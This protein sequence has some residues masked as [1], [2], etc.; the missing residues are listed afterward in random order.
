MILS[1]RKTHPEY[2]IGIVYVDAEPGTLRQRVKSRAK[3]SGREVP[4]ELI[5]QSQPAARKSAEELFE[6]TDFAMEI[7]NEDRPQIMK[8]F[9][10]GIPQSLKA[11]IPLEE[12]NLP[13]PTAE[14]PTP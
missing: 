14:R 8:V 12:M 13:W 7:R 2:S 10:N 4:D 1:L 11:P 3:E 9:K 6:Y 5:T